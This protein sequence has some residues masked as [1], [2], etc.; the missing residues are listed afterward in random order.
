MG[1]RGWWRGTAFPEVSLSTGL[2][3]LPAVSQPISTPTLSGGYHSGCLTD[4]EPQVAVP[5]KD[6]TFHS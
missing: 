3:S 4:Q 5:V 6:P 2:G 1:G